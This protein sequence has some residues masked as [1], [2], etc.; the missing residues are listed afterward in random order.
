MKLITGFIGAVLA[1]GLLTIGTEVASA[2]PRIGGYFSAGNPGG[3]PYYSGYPITHTPGNQAWE[4][5]SAWATYN[6]QLRQTPGGKTS[7]E[8]RVIIAK[9]A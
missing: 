9:R 5:N 3:L 1:I 6:G 8:T 4:T 7:T 2:G